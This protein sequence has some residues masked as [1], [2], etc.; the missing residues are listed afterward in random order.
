[1]C[2]WNEYRDSYSKLMVQTKMSLQ[3]QQYQIL[4]VI[5]AIINKLKQYEY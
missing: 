2:F 1:M 3:L 4:F 5:N